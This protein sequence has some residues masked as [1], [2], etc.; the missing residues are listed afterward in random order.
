MFPLKVKPEFEIYFILNI[1]SD[2][3]EKELVALLEEGVK[4]LES[5]YLGGS[6]SRGYGQIKIEMD[7]SNPSVV[8]KS[9][10][11]ENV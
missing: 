5:D 8:Y 1:W 11:K 6:G 7:F 2:D 3:E 4:L 9:K 10:V